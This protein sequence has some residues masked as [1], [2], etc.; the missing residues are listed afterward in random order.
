MGRGGRGFGGFGRGGAAKSSPPPAARPPPPAAAAPPA[1]APRAPGLMGQMAA[2][3]GGVAIANADWSLVGG[4]SQKFV[5][6][7]QSLLIITSHGHITAGDCNG[8]VEFSHFVDG[9]HV[10]PEMHS[11][12]PFI[13]ALSPFF[14]V[15]LHFCFFLLRFFFFA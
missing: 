9:E 13:P 3:A 8:E 4:Y 1:A 14:F 10:C 12:C 2:T 11:G 5:V 15:P 6:E 7:G